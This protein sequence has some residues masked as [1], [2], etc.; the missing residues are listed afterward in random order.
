MNGHGYDVF[1]QL[2]ERLLNRF[3][4]ALFYSGMLRHYGEYTFEDANEPVPAD[5]GSG[6]ERKLDISLEALKCF[7]TVKYDIRLKNEPY[8]DLLAAEK[9]GIRLSVE[10]RMEILGMRVEFDVSFGVS[11]KLVFDQKAN[12]LA[13]DL[14]N[15]DIIDITLNNSLTVPGIMLSQLNIVLGK[16]LKRYITDDIKKVKIPI[17]LDTLVIPFLDDGGRIR[18]ID[19]SIVDDSSLAVGVNIYKDAGGSFSSVPTL[20]DTD[21]MTALNTGAILKFARFFWESTVEKQ[22]I[23]F[24]FNIPMNPR[25]FIAKVSDIGKR[26]ISLGF[27]QQETIVNNCQADCSGNVFV[28]QFPKI[29][30]ENNRVTVSDVRVIA[31]I[32][33]KVI[34]NVTRRLIH[35]SSGFIPDRWT[36]KED[37]TLIS[38]ETFD[39][40]LFTFKTTADCNIDRALCKV[41]TDD[42]GR[43]SI[44]IVSGDLTLDF[45]DKWY[46]NLTEKGANLLL[47]LIENNLLNKIPAFVISPSML[48]D[49]LSLLGFTYSAK[50]VN[51]TLDQDEIC[52][53]VNLGINELETNGAP[54]PLYIAN[55][56]SKKLHL[57]NCPVVDGIVFAHRRGYYDVLSAMREGYKPCKNCLKGY[58]FK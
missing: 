9:I 32:D 35:D 21:I 54:H 6:T 56:K 39:D 11:A 12:T 23:P 28:K 50:L 49:D 27:S 37:D 19:F 26:I 41:Q 33:I 42:Q 22:K 24:R 16:V 38:E 15:T 14:T 13:Y 55:V 47:D 4:G 17:S 8:I 45:G 57:F 5:D 30:F 40:I 46:N 58:E 36:K 31:D 20:I 3:L 25:K 43:L 18:A 7:R 1:L 53:W 52:A 48:L 44:K 29:E 34:A 2:N 10:L 51:V